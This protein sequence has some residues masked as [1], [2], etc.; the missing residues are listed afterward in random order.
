MNHLNSVLEKVKSALNGIQPEDK[1]LREML[2][3]VSE[4]KDRE[5][6]EKVQ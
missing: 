3:A 4:K 5:L 2:T 6:E 1:Y